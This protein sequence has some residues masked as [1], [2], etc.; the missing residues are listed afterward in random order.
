VFGL[1][2]LVGLARV[3]V[4]AHVPLDVVGGAAEGLA[5]AAGLNLLFGTGGRFT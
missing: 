1:A 2:A 5:L 4:G 3:Y